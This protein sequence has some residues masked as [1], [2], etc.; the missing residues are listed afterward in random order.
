MIII[1]RDNSEFSLLGFSN[2]FWRLLGAG[3]WSKCSHR[4]ALHYNTAQVHWYMMTRSSRTF[5][6]YVVSIQFR[7][8][9]FTVSCNSRLHRTVVKTIFSVSV[10]VLY[11]KN[12]LKPT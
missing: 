10:A 6:V 4:H 3:A 8:K 12:R 2:P 1:I 9:W 5:Y 7:S 11:Y